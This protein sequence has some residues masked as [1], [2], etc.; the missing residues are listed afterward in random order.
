MVSKVM[1]AD[2]WRDWLMLALAVWLFISPWALGFAP[3]AEGAETAANLGAA[4]WNAWLLAIVIGGLAIWAI[5]AFAEWHDWLNGVLGVWLVVAP[6]ILQFSAAA[7]ATWN[8]V[9]VGLLVVA[10]AAWELW[11]V[12]HQ[13]RATA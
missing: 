8:H 12:R 11:V 13:Q 6:W 2:R 7:A 3:P 9:I 10:F 5:V 4:S 1:S